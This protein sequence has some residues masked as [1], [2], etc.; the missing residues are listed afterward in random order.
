MLIT[1]VMIFQMYNFAERLAMGAAF[2]VSWRSGLAMSLDSFK[3]SCCPSFSAGD[4]AIL[5]HSGLSI[6]KTLLLNVGT[7]QRHIVFYFSGVAYLS[8]TFN[9]PSQSTPPYARFTLARLFLPTLLHNAGLLT[10][11]VLRNLHF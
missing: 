4:F 6:C 9:S 11:W 3:S 10:G 5:L 2:S 8:V 1:T 7:W